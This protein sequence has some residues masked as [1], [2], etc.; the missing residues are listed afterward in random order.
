MKFIVVTNMRKPIGVETKTER[1]I[2]LNV[3]QIISFEEL[4][5][6]LVD[7]YDAK[8]EIQTTRTNVYVKE[9]VEEILLK[10]KDCNSIA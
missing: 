1:K 10:I 9:S 2:F 7:V 4:E 6:L 8:S 3:N 5:D